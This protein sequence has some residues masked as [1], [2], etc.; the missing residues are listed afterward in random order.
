[1]HAAHSKDIKIALTYLQPGYTHMEADS[2]HRIIEKHKKSTNAVIEIP[3][4]WITTIRSTHR[5][6]KPNV[7]SME[8]TDFKNAKHLFADRVLINRSK[9]EDGEPVGWLKMRRI[10]YGKEKRKMDLVT[11]LL[12]ESKVSTYSV[13]RREAN[14]VETVDWTF[15]QLHN[16]QLPIGA[17]KLKDLMDLLPLISADNRPFYLNLKSVEDTERRRRNGV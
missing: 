17:K 6:K 14:R 2:I 5:S 8:R 9:N 10:F 1:M 4:D 7:I 16:E 12:E 11:S 15:P 13:L 3:R